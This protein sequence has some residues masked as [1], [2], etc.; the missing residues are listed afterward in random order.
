MINQKH[1]PG[2]NKKTGNKEITSRVL[3]IE[4]DY[5]LSRVMMSVNIPCGETTFN[6]DNRRKNI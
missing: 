2:Q 6:E 4:A 5:R 1:K 3:P